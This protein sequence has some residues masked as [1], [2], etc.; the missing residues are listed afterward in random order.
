MPALLAG[1][2]STEA[3]WSCW[4]LVR[5]PRA[6]LKVNSALT[7][8]LKGRAF[9]HAHYHCRSAPDLPGN[10]KPFERKLQR[11]RAQLRRASAALLPTGLAPATAHSLDRTLKSLVPILYP[12]CIQAIAIITTKDRGLINIRVSKARTKVLT[13]SPQL[14]ALRC[15]GVVRQLAPQRGASID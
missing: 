7:S 6:V 2:A 9:T 4:A 5:V 13:Q 14:P 1:A 11:D 3:R 10:P 12:P 8:K 15:L